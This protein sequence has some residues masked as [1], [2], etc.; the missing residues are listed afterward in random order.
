MIITVNEISRRYLHVT[1]QWEGE[2]NQFWSTF[3]RQQEVTPNQTKHV[4]H[5]YNHNLIFPKSLVVYVSAK[6]EISL[7]QDFCLG[8]ETSQRNVLAENKS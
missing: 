1:Q 5:F 7:K 2:K 6:S 8:T 4:E 3:F